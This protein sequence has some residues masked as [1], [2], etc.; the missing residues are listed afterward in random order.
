MPETGLVQ[1]AVP[2]APGATWAKCVLWGGGLSTP[3]A[4]QSARRRQGACPTLAWWIAGH[5]YRLRD[6]SSVRLENFKPE[7]RIVAR[8]RVQ[9][10][11]AQDVRFIQVQ[12][13]RLLPVAIVNGERGAA[14][15][16]H[17]PRISIPTYQQ[18]RRIAL[19]PQPQYGSRAGGGGLVARRTGGAQIS[20]HRDD[21]RRDRN[22]DGGG[23]Q[24]KAK[25]G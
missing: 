24:P 23:S 21:Q 12:G 14:G 10:A 3:A 8:W 11:A 5:P 25:P 4:V 16:G 13:F 18:V 9:I 17:L 15:A 6:A 2:P 22:H 19:Y 7:L 20:D 1:R